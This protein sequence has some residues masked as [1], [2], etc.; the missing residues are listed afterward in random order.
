MPLNG[1]ILCDAP[2]RI[3]HIRCIE[4]GRAPSDGGK[5]R[6][7]GHHG[8]RVGLQMEPVGIVPGAYSTDVCHPVH[9][10][11]ATQSTG[12][13]PLSPWESCHPVHGKPATWTTGRL[14]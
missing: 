10:K 6:R 4:D 13:L 14:P 2:W 9:G 1:D 5:V 3:D 11:I 7:R 8:G 12:R